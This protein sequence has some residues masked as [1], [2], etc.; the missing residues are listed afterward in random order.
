MVDA[1]SVQVELHYI[2]VGVRS[3]SPWPNPA[4]H[5]ACMADCRQPGVRE[6][7][8]DVVAHRLG[9]QD[10]AGGDVGI[11]LALGHQGKN[12]VFA[13]RQL[14]EEL[15]GATL[16]GWSSA[17]EVAHQVLGDGRTKDGRRRPARMARKVSSCTAPLRGESKRNALRWRWRGRRTT[18]SC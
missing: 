1:Q 18:L 8:G 7:V 16:R 6:D 11:G 12:S 15:C 3:P 5:A 13:V 4:V 10:E 9:A 17:A 14:R 2:S